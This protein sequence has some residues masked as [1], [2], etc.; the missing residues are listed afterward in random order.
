MHNVFFVS[1]CFGFGNKRYLKLYVVFIERHEA[2][3]L[4]KI[5][6]DFRI[7]VAVIL[8]FQLAAIAAKRASPK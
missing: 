5:L 2:R 1:F 8:D 7:R 3:F 4:S 6:I